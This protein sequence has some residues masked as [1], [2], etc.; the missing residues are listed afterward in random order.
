MDLKVLI[1]VLKRFRDLSGLMRG[2][3]NFAEIQKSMLYTFFYHCFQIT[4]ISNNYFI[5]RNFNVESSAQTYINY[6]L[7]RCIE[8]RVKFW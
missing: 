3:G 4:S 8:T 2:W 6:N 5:G 7:A 1:L